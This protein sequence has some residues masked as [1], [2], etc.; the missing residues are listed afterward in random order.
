M[1]RVL[2]LLQ[3][4]RWRGSQLRTNV[5]PPEDVVYK[6]GRAVWIKKRIKSDTIFESDPLW[7]AIAA[8]APAG[9]EYSHITANKNV[10][11]HPHVDGNNSGT[12]H[13]LFLGDFCGGAL[14]FEDGTRITEAGRWHAFD[15]RVRH[16]N[17][18]H[19]GDKYSII[20]YSRRRRGVGIQG[21]RKVRPGEGSPDT[22][23]V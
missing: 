9:A 6:G 12:S 15:G 10:T 18:P 23:G 2:E 1:E 22:L 4:R 8:I 3:T 21:W 14:L 17:E 11:C 20:L 19:T 13:I 5:V 16:W 7:D